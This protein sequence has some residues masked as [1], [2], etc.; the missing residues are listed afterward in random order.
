MTVQKIDSDDVSL[1]DLFEGFFLVPDYQREY[2]WETEQVEQLLLDIY[3][4]FSED[5]KFSESEYFV[6]S[7]VCCPGPDNLVE[8]IDG[9]QRMTTA[10]LF[11]CTLRDHLAA[12]GEAPPTVLEQQI[13][14]VAVD[15]FGNEIARQRLVL[16]YEDSKDILNQIAS[17]KVPE[18]LERTRSID[19]ILNAYETIRA[20]LKS[21]FQNEASELRHFWAFFTQQVKLIRIQTQSVAHALKIF[22]TI[23]DRGKGLDAMDLLKNLMFMHADTEQFDSLKRHWKKLVDTLYAAGEKPLRF[24]RY[25]IFSEYNVERLKEEEIYDWFLKNKELCGYGSDPVGFVR[26]LLK[27]AEAYVHFLDGMDSRG[28]P[29][30]YLVNMKF[31]SGAARQHLILLLAAR[32]LPTDAFSELCREVENL[33]FAYIIT[34]ENT[35]DF[36]RNF[37]R[38]APDLREVKD[39]TGLRDFVGKRFTPA[40]EAL[41]QRFQLAF[42]ELREDSIQKY[43]MRYVLGKLA[44]YVNEQAYDRKEKTE[45]TRLETFINSKVHVEHILPQTPSLKVLEEFDLTEEIL[46]W[47]PRLG[48]LTLAEE[49]IN[50]SLGNRPFSEKTLEYPKSKFLITRVIS[51]DQSFGETAISKAVEP[52]KVYSEWTSKSIR[53]RQEILGEVATLTWNMPKAKSDSSEKESGNGDRPS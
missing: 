42:E 3:E 24:L 13:A 26:R 49:A 25:Y 5:G 36:E 32:A 2:V 28:E 20:F 19:N 10:F 18:D 16:Q 17:Q 14:H 22:E 21:H 8:L 44:Q 34:R 27:A 37:A 1:S 9:Q 23:N 31:L 15:G 43:R 12:F 33:F 6:G 51:S 48:N 46:D 7:I 47:I 52:F 39:I 45:A 29:N 40:K 38:W 41:A 30:R 4:A 50:E 11:L 53:D 35:R